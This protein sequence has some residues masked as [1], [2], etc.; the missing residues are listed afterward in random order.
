MKYKCEKC[1]MCFDQK[2]NYTRH[3]TKKFSCVKEEKEFL[4]LQDRTCKY[5]GKTFLYKYCTTRHLTTCKFRKNNETDELKQM[6]ILLN[7]KIDNLHNKQNVTNNIQNNIHNNI[8]NNIQQNIIVN[9][10]GKEDMSH[11]TS[12]DYKNIIKKGCYAIP[13]LMKYVHCNDKKP[14]NRNIYIKNYKDDY[15]LTF[16]GYEWNIEKKDDIFGNIIENKKNFLE[17]KYDDYYNELSKPAKSTFK[18][19]LERSDNNEVINNIKDELRNEFYKNRK[20]VNKN[21][22]KKPTKIKNKKKI[23]K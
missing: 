8:Q 18:K 7:N 3:M 4:N 23:E 14:E 12:D 5:C 16:D 15:I 19:F 10:Y 17:T 1:G 22:V 9:A 21:I 11:I 13:E 2:S 6:I 20:H